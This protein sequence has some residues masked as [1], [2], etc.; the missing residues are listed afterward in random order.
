[1]KTKSEKMLF[2]N[3]SIEMI[4]FYSRKCRLQMGMIL[5][6]RYYCACAEN[7]WFSLIRAQSRTIRCFRYRT[8]SINNIII[9]DVRIALSGSTDLLYFGFGRKTGRVLRSK[10]VRDGNINNCA[11][12]TDKSSGGPRDLRASAP[13]R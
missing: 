10:T 7:V 1:M 8:R 12:P 2:E 3:Q 4:L 6:S 9:H 13:L 5:F 11:G